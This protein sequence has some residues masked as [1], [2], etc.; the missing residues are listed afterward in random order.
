M[1]LPA[2]HISSPSHR[3]GTKSQLT[4]D[5]S[6]IKSVTPAYAGKVVIKMGMFPRIPEPE[7]ET[8]GD[9]RHHWQGHHPDMT[10]YKIKA[11][12]AVLEE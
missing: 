8:F 1:H 5:P 3:S 4:F 6:P 10:K 12:E 11:K 2:L 9:H 7:Y